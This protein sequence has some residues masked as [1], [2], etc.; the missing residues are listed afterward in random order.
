VRDAFASSLRVVWQVMIGVGV[1]GLMA[2]L[3][4][5]HLP[6][7]TSIDEKWGISDSEQNNT[8]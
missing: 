5:E 2:S 8:L 7:H 6:L 1:L 4:M 3:A